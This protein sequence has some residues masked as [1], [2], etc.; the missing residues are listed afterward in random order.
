MNLTHLKDIRECLIDAYGHDEDFKPHL[1]AICNAIQDEIDLVK[2]ARN[3]SEVDRY[4][5][6]DLCDN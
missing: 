2:R 3:L 6:L 4:F 1:V 5:K